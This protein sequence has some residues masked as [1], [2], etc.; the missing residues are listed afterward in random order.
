M[1]AA[2][3]V[4][5]HASHAKPADGNSVVS[6]HRSGWQLQYGRAPAS[7][8]IRLPQAFA[9]LP[10]SIRPPYAGTSSS[11]GPKPLFCGFGTV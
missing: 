4:A 8:R 5:G 3:L 2:V 11:Y 6:D 10:I 7:P 9:T 1:G